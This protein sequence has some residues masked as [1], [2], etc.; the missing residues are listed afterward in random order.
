MTA[1]PSP[2][3]RFG[4]AVNCIDGRVQAPVADWLKV[5]YHLDY[6]DAITEPGVDGA[7]PASPEVADQV[8]ARLM[9]SIHRHGS[10]VVAL[11]GHHDCATNPVSS[12]QHW[13]QIRQSLQ[14]IRFWNVPMTVIG[15]WVNE[16][17][18]VEVVSA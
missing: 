4:T 18:E 8:K 13:Q 3:G 16:R 5:H 6:V 7:L 12:D 9:V 11:A 1:Q 10:T 17:W 2:Q 14:V 15:L